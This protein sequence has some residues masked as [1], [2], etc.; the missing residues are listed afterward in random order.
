MQREERDADNGIK[1]GIIC[2]LFSPSLSLPHL[3]PRHQQLPA[4]AAEMGPCYHGYERWLL[5][6]TRWGLVINGRIGRKLIIYPR[7]GGAFWATLPSVMG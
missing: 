4:A 5:R 6:S 2:L 1:A 7:E 3:C